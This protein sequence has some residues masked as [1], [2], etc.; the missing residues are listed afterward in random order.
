MVAIDDNTVSVGKRKTRG[1]VRFSAG[2]TA[3]YDHGGSV[4]TAITLPNT[5]R[6]R[7]YTLDGLGNWQDKMITMDVTFSGAGSL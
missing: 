4:A 1:E 6:S 5:D 2:Q 7:N 3:A